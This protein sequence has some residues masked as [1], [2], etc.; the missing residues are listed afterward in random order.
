M[1]TRRGGGER[2]G[3]AR[4]HGRPGPGGDL[5]ASC[6]Q[7]GR[8]SRG[9]PHASSPG[10]PSSLRDEAVNAGQ[11]EKGAG[12]TTNPDGGRERSPGR[13]G[14]DGDGT[15]TP[16]RR[17]GSLFAAR[18]APLS[19]M[20]QRTGTGTQ[21]S[22][23]VPP[24]FQPATATCSRRVAGSCGS[25]SPGP[26]TARGPSSEQEAGVEVTAGPHGHLGGKARLPPPRGSCQ[27]ISAADRL[28]PS[29]VVCRVAGPVRRTHAHGAA[30]RL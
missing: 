28:F 27:P 22:T 4:F 24:T 19:E 20:P 23:R 15:P 16:T 25:G 1:T 18:Q 9:D 8:A 17:T 26:E 13:G 14:W 12:F 2:T 21:P 6:M 5:G 7:E 29:H 11:R 10:P 30:L 3:E